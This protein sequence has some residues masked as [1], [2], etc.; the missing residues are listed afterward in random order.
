MMRGYRQN[1]K[2]GAQRML[3]L[4]CRWAF[5]L[6]YSSTFWALQFSRQMLHIT[7]KINLFTQWAVISGKNYFKVLIVNINGLHKNLEG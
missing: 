7:F 1:H 5:E 2:Q 6:Y 3:T 4:L